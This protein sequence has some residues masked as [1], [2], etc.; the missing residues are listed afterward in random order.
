MGQYECGKKRTARKMFSTNHKLRSI[1]VYPGP[2]IQQ[3][4]RSL[5]RTQDHDRLR[6]QPHPEYRAVLLRPFLLL[7]PLVFE[8]NLKE[9]SEDG[10][11]AGARGERELPPFL[12]KEIGGC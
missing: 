8:R 5:V 10:N 12:L 6:A 11:S 1:R 9:V 2:L 7:A 4:P 3:I